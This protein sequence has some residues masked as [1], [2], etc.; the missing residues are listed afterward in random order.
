MGAPQLSVYFAIF[1]QNVTPVMIAA[2]NNKITIMKQLIKHGADVNL[3]DDLGEHALLV[4]GVTRSVN[5]L[6]S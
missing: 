1:A 6:P 4:V 3:Q 5:F 2:E